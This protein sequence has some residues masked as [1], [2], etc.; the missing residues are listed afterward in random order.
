LI[1]VGCIIG[2]I[3]GGGISLYK[4]SVPSVT[5]IWRQSLLALFGVFICL[6]GAVIQLPDGDGTANAAEGN[7]PDMTG[8]NSADNSAILNSD[9]NAA[10]L[11]NSSNAEEA[12]VNQTTDSGEAGN[13]Q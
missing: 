12:S 5:S 6:F 9:S 8:D 1:G 13:T 11:S 4:L 10:D 2:G 3:V 7:G